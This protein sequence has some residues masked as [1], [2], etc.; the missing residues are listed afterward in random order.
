MGENKTV[1]SSKV[2]RPLD[3]QDGTEEDLSIDIEHAK[4]IVGGENMLGTRFALRKFVI[5]Q[6]F[7]S[8]SVSAQETEELTELPVL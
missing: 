1:S 6:S 3:H 5:G 2:W 4:V 8:P 7:T